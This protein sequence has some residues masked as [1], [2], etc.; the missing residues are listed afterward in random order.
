MHEL[1]LKI[2][3]DIALVGYGDIDSAKLLNPPLTTVRVPVEEMAKA[4]IKKYFKQN[5]IFNNVRNVDLNRKLL[6][7]QNK[8]KIK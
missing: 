6:K 2:P 3:E 1:K 7:C 5:K 4:A 8:L